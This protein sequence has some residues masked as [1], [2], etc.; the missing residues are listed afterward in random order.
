VQAV[1]L[2]DGRLLTGGN[3]F[4]AR[5]WDARTG[6]MIR[7]FRGHTASVDSVDVNRDGT[8]IL[9]FSH[10][11]R[12][13]RIWNPDDDEELW[14]LSGQTAPALFAPDGR[15]ILTGGR[16]GVIRRVAYTSGTILR[17]FRSPGRPPGSWD[18]LC[19]LPGGRHFLA[20]DSDRVL[21]LWDLETGRELYRAEHLGQATAIAVT[22]DCRHALLGTDFGSVLKWRLPP[23]RQGGEEVAEKPGRA[24]EVGEVRLMG[25]EGRIARVHFLPDGEHVLAGGDSLTLWNTRTGEKIRVFTGAEL[26]G[27]HLPMNISRDGRYALAGFHFVDLKTGKKLLTLEGAEPHGHLAGVAFSPD[28]SRAVLGND[29][30]RPIGTL[31][32]ADLKTGKPWKI[33]DTER[34]VRAVAYSPDGRCIAAGLCKPGTPDTLRVYKVETGKIL[35]SFTVPTEPGCIAFSADGKQLV[36]SHDKTLYLWDLKTEKELKRFE[37]HTGFIEAVVFTPDGR[38]VISAGWDQAVRM[39]NLAQGQEVACLRGHMDSS[40][41]VSV[42]PDG[43]HVV[44]G[45]GDGLVRVWHLPSSRS[46]GEETAEHSPQSEA[47]RLVQVRR[48]ELPLCEKNR[49]PPHAYTAAFSSDGTMYAA[50]G[51]DGLVRVWN[52]QTGQLL[53]TLS[54]RTGWLRHIAFTPDSKRLVSSDELTLRVWDMATGREFQRL[55]VPKEGAGC[56]D[57]A[58]D[59]THLVANCLDNTVRIWNLESAQ[60]IRCLQVGEACEALFLADGQRIVTW[61]RADTL[62]LWD[63]ATGTPLATESGPPLSVKDVRTARGGKM[64]LVAGRDGLSWRDPA[65]LRE[66]RSLKRRGLFKDIN[67]AVSPDGRFLIVADP[68]EAGARLWDLEAGKEID[69]LELS[70][71]PSMHMAFAPDGR[72]IA[73]GS[74]RGFVYLLRIEEVAAKARQKQP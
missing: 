27:W 7:E 73:A 28:G 74:F 35:H 59:G 62:K 20:A 41:G 22:P 65:T 55:P 54:D 32:V 11:E 70:T 67:W 66:L 52:R 19:L 57:I 60:E 48:H 71:R 3:D 43:R 23:L 14:R 36:S 26:R 53:H 39:W 38:H 16:D 5:L 34:R 13:V 63:A 25:G 72:H 17:S 61:N 18:R 33:Y 29:V 45:C 2:P 30:G 31:W 12:T 47:P 10:R 49:I 40:C 64:L 58:P 8:R 6:E 68:N 69:Y 56:L 9:T 50:G 46:G 21:R 15:S 51:D 37:G 44:T 1:W 42:A 24:E 4:I